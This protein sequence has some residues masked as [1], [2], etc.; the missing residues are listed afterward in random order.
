MHLKPLVR[1]L[2]LAGSMAC[3]A[4]SA[5]AW[6][7]GVSRESGVTLSGFIDLNY[8]HISS[9]GKYTKMNR[10]TSGGL[11]SSRINISGHEYLGNGNE[12]FFTIE[13]QFNANDGMYADT[14]LRQSFV[15]LRGESWGE[16]SMGRQFTPSF[17]VTGY[18]DPNW[19]SAYSMM[20]SMVYYYAAYRVNNSFSYKSPNIGGFTGRLFYS[21]G[22]GD[23]KRNNGRFYSASI[24]YRNG[25]LWL[26]F[27]HQTQYTG[28]VPYS[29][30][31]SVK[32]SRDNFF[33]AAYRFG[34]VEPTFVF[35]T[36]DGH[37]A[38]LPYD[39]FEA[40]GWSAQLGVRWSITD[41]HKVHASFVHRQDRSYKDLSG[42]DKN[43]ANG[44]TIGYMYG[45]SKRTTLYATAS[46]VWNKKDASRSYPIT[47]NNATPEAGQSP[48]GYQIGIRH[49]F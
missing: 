39:Q 4:G 2:L 1:N 11:N 45:L 27:V 36:Y 25:P 28:Q 34:S 15:G 20:N 26:G 14:P 29:N 7:D 5:M 30:S 43:K 32:T 24:E 22:D 8:E 19:A 47:W 9:S 41:Q 37:Y 17:W 10:Q 21:N 38:Y 33:S 18:A 49:A 6:N 31:D 12:A 42:G 23:T 48:T 3:M 44:L 40:S 13:P 16:I 35:H 46:H